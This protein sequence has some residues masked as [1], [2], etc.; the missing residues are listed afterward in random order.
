MGIIED[1]LSELKKCVEA[2]IPDSK[3]VSCVPAM[4]RVEVKWVLQIFEI[5]NRI[6]VRQI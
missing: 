2:Q 3:L 4:I 1:E 6:V 5:K